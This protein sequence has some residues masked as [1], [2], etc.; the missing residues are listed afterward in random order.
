[1]AQTATPLFLGIRA[2]DEVFSDDDVDMDAPAT[3]YIFKA[4]ISPD[5]EIVSDEDDDEADRHD[6]PP[7]T[8]DPLRL[9]D[10]GASVQSTRHHMPAAAPTPAP[11]AAAAAAFSPARALVVNPSHAGTIP[12]RK[13]QEFKRTFSVASPHRSSPVGPSAAAVAAAAA[14]SASESPSKRIKLSGDDAAPLS[15]ALGAVDLG[16]QDSMSSSIAATPSVATFKLPPPPFSGTPR[17]PLLATEPGHVTDP[18]LL[19]SHGVRP[20]LGPRGVRAILAEGGRRLR[21]AR[22]AANLTATAAVD[23][24]RLLADTLVPAVT[25]E[26]ASG[27]AATPVSA[28]VPQNGNGNGKQPRQVI[29]GVS[30]I[31]FADVAALFPPRSDPRVLCELLAVLF[32]P[33]ADPAAGTAVPPVVAMLATKTRL[34]SWLHAHLE[35]DARDAATRAVA[36]GNVVAAV[37]ALV[38]ARHLADAA[39]IAMHNGAPGLAAY[40]ACAAAA[41]DMMRAKAAA[42]R[43]APAGVEVDPDLVRIF[44][45][46][47][48][49]PEDVDGNN[50]LP[51][52]RTGIAALQGLGFARAMAHLLDAFPKLG[53]DDAYA[54]Y[55][56]LEPHFATP[57]LGGD[58]AHV[59]RAVLNLYASPTAADHLRA[60]VHLAVDA[61]AGSAMPDYTPAVV[62]AVGLRAAGIAL[63]APNATRLLTRA[64]AALET[65]GEW[66][67]AVFC[68]QLMHLWQDGDKA[69]CAAREAYILEVVSRNVSAD[70]VDGVEG[71]DEESKL[72][73]LPANE[74][75]CVTTFRVPLRVLAQAKVLRIGYVVDSSRRMFGS[76]TAGVGA[77]AS[78]NVMAAASCQPAS[79]AESVAKSI[80]ATPLSPSASAASP[81]LGNVRPRVS[82][83][84]IYP[85][86]LPPKSPAD[87]ARETRRRL[88][89][90][91]LAPDRRMLL[92]VASAALRAVVARAVVEHRI[93]D[94]RE[95]VE[96]F[97]DATAAFFGREPAE[98][99][100]VAAAVVEVA[101]VVDYFAA[102]VVPNG[103]AAKREILRGMATDVAEAVMRRARAEGGLSMDEVAA[104][105]LIPHL[106]HEKYGATVV[107]PLAGYDRAWP[108][109]LLARD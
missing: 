41:P 73:R 48:L 77:A 45:L 87:R 98:L 15:R 92:P 38:E 59:L 22:Y 55:T 9:A 66:P 37:L 85:R 14:A 13:L 84:A 4:G 78:P 49:G 57:A 16:S 94:A 50:D 58:N 18:A 100:L 21:I 88:T 24:A 6:A 25:Y 5:T 39:H 34:Q 102:E 52:S 91:L 81:L 8:D 61:A 95:A 43:N 97:C 71:W 67:A 40:I 42:L 86:A 26:P 101:K 65:A 30:R 28:T 12:I 2:D 31:V 96:E 54:L 99:P 90:A 53:I 44:D 105:E 10:L 64:A 70:L 60:V 7:V 35:G 3:K 106:L 74:R 11:V 108:T 23:P 32:D 93:A 20:I 107:S 27:A 75:E 80:R 68:L 83:T 1:M 63:P 19:K 82:S 33:M 62:V 104:L 46:L 89:A 109:N 47:G 51:V 72:A 103:D 36:D 17:R 69:E 29:S 76:P 56:Q 79:L